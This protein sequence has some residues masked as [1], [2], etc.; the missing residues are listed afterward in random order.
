MST[1]T[2]H[3]R[4]S[5]L[6][7]APTRARSRSK[8][9]QRRPSLGSRRSSA[10]ISFISF[11]NDYDP[12]AVTPVLAPT[13]SSGLPPVSPSLLPSS[14]PSIPPST[15]PLLTSNGS[16]E[17]EIP[18]ISASLDH[19]LPAAYFKQDLLS[20]LKSLRVSKWHKLPSQIYP[21][22]KLTKISG[23]L[24]NAIYRVDPP[25]VVHL[26]NLNLH[27]VYFPTLLLR[28]Y[29][30]NGESLIDRQYELKM[31]VRL[32]KQNIGP[33]LFGCFTNG[34]IEQYL[35]N[36][37]TL[38]RKDIH[39]KKTSSRIA[40]R[41]K[42]LHS[43]IRLYQWEKDQGPSAWR[44]IEKWIDY[45]ETGLAN[46]TLELDE[47]SIFKNDFQT[48]KKL[49]F[50]YKKWLFDRYES[51]HD[52]KNS[53]VFCHNDTQYGNLLFTTQPK[54]I[55]T[56]SNSS[57]TTI[58]ATSKDGKTNNEA[59][60]STTSSLKTKLSNLSLDN[61]NEIRPSVQEKKQDRNL[62]VIDFEYSGPNVPAFD[63]AN[64]FCEWMSNY[65]HPTRSFA[66]FDEDFPTLDEQLNLIYSYILF[67]SEQN[68]DINKLEKQAKKLFN[69]CIAWRA[70]VSIHWGLWAIVQNGEKKSIENSNEILETGPNGEQY[71]IVQ[72]S[73]PSAVESDDETSSS[74]DELNNATENAHTDSDNFEYL[75][76]CEEKLNCCWGDLI[77]LG[78]IKKDDL[79]LDGNEESIKFLFADFF[80][81]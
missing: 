31:L 33:R 63:I 29:G 19:T 79:Y 11:K 3:H 71:K 6:K 48:F 57:T 39:D 23:A 67:N 32:S 38:T 80:D 27:N 35:D 26:K 52:L 73:S 1:D 37:T 59:S 40:R 34:R 24:T 8:S 14:H 22:L 53:I 65:D 60:T 7:T 30:S 64:H 56:S 51:L 72:N 55:P 45:I 61:L 74:D 9:K 77:Q 18:S 2:I 69:D 20:V 62:V 21:E 25:S 46:K 16:Y 17:T 50:K 44:S 41:M 54:K 28:I 68:P 36:A 13:S 66:V 12:S 10:N 15:A 78:I 42:E 5:S 70:T 49:I 43:G 47:N 75:K 81:V 4:R 76:Y 58:P